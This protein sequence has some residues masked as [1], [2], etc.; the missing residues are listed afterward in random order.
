M[1]T[2]KQKGAMSLFGE[3]YGDEVRVLTMGDG[4]SIELCGGTHTLRT[5]NIGVFKIIS[6]AGIA[7]GIRRIEAVTGEAVL[8]HFDRL[9]QDLEGVCAV[10]KTSPKNILEKAKSLLAE[11]KGLEKENASLQS[12]ISGKAGSDLL[13]QAKE[14]SG[15]NVL[16][17]VLE[18]VDPKTLRD[19][20]DQVKNK[21]AE[22]IVVLAVIQGDKI[23]LVS[24]LT[25]GIPE[26][27][28]AGD[29]MQFVASQLD[30]KGGGRRDMAQGGGTKI[31]A[32]PEVMSSVFVWVKEKLI[33]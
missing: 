12:K 27:I 5:G 4:F 11:S 29:L 8:N 1:K 15:I 31:I 19:T 13:S 7:A 23:S 2:A 30:G 6:E 32:L 25:K 33:D 14:I 10:F 24:G 17:V 20:V 26:V 28:H 22:S 9:E 16:S 3:K 21:L 18:G